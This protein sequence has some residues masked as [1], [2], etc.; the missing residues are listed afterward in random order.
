MKITLTPIS[1]FA[2][3]CCLLWFCVS[4]CLALELGI[5]L[6]LSTDN[7]PE[8]GGNK[9]AFDVSGVGTCTQAGRVITVSNYTNTVWAQSPRRVTDTTLLADLSFIG[10]NAIVLAGLRTELVTVITTPD[11]TEPFQLR[12][13][14]S[15]NPFNSECAFTLDEVQTYKCGNDAT[16]SCS[17]CT[18]NFFAYPGKDT[19]NCFGIPSQCCGSQ[20]CC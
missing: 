18:L 5:P 12:V 6:G 4:V 15:V 3:G 14:G 9:T 16:F 1:L 13:E 2:S 20:G 10:K 7:S 8:T 17:K 19:G 11:G